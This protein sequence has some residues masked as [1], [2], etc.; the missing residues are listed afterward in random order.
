M[1]RSEQQV[2]AWPINANT[3]GRSYS[4]SHRD[5]MVRVP[6]LSYTSVTGWSATPTFV[7]S[8]SS[9]RII[10]NA[11]AVG[12]EAAINGIRIDARY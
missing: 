10:G 1:Y 8:T 6:S 9:F 7:S 2:Y 12:Q 4:L 5:D 3:A 11:T